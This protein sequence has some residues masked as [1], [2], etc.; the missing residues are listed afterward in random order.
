MSRIGNQIIILPAGTTIAQEG[1]EAIVQGSKGTLKVVVPTGISFLVKELTVEVARS[2]D[3]YKAVH[4]L[5]RALLNNA[6]VGVSQGWTRDLEING[7]GLRASV[8]GEG[9]ALN[10]GFSHP[11]MF[12]IP[13]GVQVNVVKNVINLSGIDK[14]LV[15]EVAAQIRKL[16]KP[17]PYKGKGIKFSNEVIRRKAGKAGKAGK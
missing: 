3:E 1:I 11:V 5:F 9:L 14:Q 15:G 7:V 4:G 2:G 8:S 13:E 17:E 10:L 12:K 16:K 6:I